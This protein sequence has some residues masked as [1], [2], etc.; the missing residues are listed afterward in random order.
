[1]FEDQGDCN[2]ILVKE[3]YANW[4][5]KTRFNKTVP[6]RGKNVKFTSKVLNLFLGTSNCDAEDYNRLKENPLY[7]DSRHTLC[8]A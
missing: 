8:G 3:F 5:T 4:N 7:R 6:I 1:M 2:L